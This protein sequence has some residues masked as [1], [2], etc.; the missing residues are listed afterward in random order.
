MLRNKGCADGATLLLEVDNSR[1]GCALLCLSH[2]DCVAFAY[3]YTLPADMCKLYSTICKDA[4]IDN[5]HTYD[6]G[7]LNS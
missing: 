1:H 6:K 2:S 3:H 4:T 5:I 7:N